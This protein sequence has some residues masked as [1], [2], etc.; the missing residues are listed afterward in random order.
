MPVLK[1]PTNVLSSVQGCTLMPCAYVHYGV[2]R[3]SVLH[4]GIPLNQRYSGK[5]GGAS[6]VEQ[7]NTRLDVV[8]LS[9]NR[10]VWKRLGDEDSIKRRTLMIIRVDLSMG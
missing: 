3:R 1:P 2:N 6:E 7:G 4:G 8:G 10:F 5:D 9:G